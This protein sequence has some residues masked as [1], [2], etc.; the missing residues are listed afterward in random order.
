MRGWT[1]AFVRFSCEAALCNV[2]LA[3]A[4]SEAPFSMDGMDLIAHTVHNHIVSSKPRACA[5]VLCAQHV[6]R[7]VVPLSTLEDTVLIYTCS[8]TLCVLLC[9]ASRELHL[10]GT[11]RA[12]S[13][14]TSTCQDVQ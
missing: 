8:I 9:R 3:L 6:L 12:T 13:C 7:S 2:S 11:D 14:S 5:H 4:R 10:Y 1:Q